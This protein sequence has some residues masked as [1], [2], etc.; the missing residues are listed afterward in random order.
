MNVIKGNLPFCQ[1]NRICAISLPVKMSDRLEIGFCSVRGDVYI[2][3]ISYLRLTAVELAG[4][5]H[6]SL[7]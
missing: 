1:D 6:A 5:L 4:S 2:S 3:F 7:M